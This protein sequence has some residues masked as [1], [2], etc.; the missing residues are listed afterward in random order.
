MADKPIQQAANEYAE[1]VIG[2]IKEMLDAL[3]HAQEC[4]GKMECGQC[5]GSGRLDATNS[6]SH[7]DE[8]CPVCNGEG[9]IPCNFGEGSDEPEAWHDEERAMREVLGIF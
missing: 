8:E 7:Q 6:P 2:S 9:G 5:D 1:R 3:D 4:N